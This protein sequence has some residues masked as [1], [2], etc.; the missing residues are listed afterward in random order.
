MVVQSEDARI[1]ALYAG[2]LSMG[3]VSL[4]LKQSMLFLQR[5]PLTT[6]VV[7]IFYDLQPLFVV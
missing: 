3:E 1:E 2:L 6:T 4:L 5:Y 7:K